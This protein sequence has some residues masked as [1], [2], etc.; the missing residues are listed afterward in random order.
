MKLCQ[1]IELNEN[2]KCLFIANI[3]MNSFEFSD[4]SPLNKK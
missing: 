2:V 4:D 3:S 1:D